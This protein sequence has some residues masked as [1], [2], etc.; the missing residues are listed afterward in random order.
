MIISLLNIA[1]VAVIISMLDGT[2][3]FRNE[4]GAAIIA[5]PFLM[6]VEI[7]YGWCW[8]T[9]KD[10]ILGSDYLQLPSRRIAKD[11]KTSRFKE[12]SIQ[13]SDIK[14]VEVIQSEESDWIDL[15]D[16]NKEERVIGLKI[17]TIEDK[18]YSILDRRHYP[19]KKAVEYILNY[20]AK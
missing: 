14:T 8:L 18:E 3:L 11:F 9:T 17:I 13:F 10:Y 5:F 4:E 16:Y 2:H 12:S 15:S 7:Y 20:Q 1:I 19:L 6:M